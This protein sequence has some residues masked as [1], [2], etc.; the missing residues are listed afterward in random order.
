MPGELA[1][2][3]GQFLG[4]DMKRQIWPL[5]ITAI[6]AF[7]ILAAAFFG[8]RVMDQPP[9]GNLG[10]RIGGV[11]D[12]F[13]TGPLIMLMGAIMLY[14]MTSVGLAAAR[15]FAWLGGFFGLGG[16]LQIYI[17]GPSPLVITLAVVSLVSAVAV[18][19]LM[20]IICKKAIPGRSV[21][22]RPKKGESGNYN[23]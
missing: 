23:F 1:N 20:Q 18:I 14:T 5:A 21:M 11:L 22:G 19:V 2:S 7:A 12:S 4:E 3:I 9:G 17:H 15:F 13:L 8:L 6:L 10:A 16:L